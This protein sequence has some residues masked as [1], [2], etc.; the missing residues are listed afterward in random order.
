M[1]EKEI[2]LESGGTTYV[3]TP[4]LGALRE[5]SKRWANIQDAIADLRGLNFDACSYIVAAATG[6][7]PGQADQAVFDAGLAKATA[8]CVEWLAFVINP[9][10]ADAE[11]SQPGNP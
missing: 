10:G 6:L 4:S 3:L 5:V 1:I 2:K 9:D 8:A 7:K 11:E